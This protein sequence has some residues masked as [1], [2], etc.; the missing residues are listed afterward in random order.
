MGDRLVTVDGRQVV[1]SAE[2]SK[3]A[4][5]LIVEDEALVASSIEEVLAELGFHVAGIAASGP[6][7]LSL[8][9]QSQ[10]ALALASRF[11]PPTESDSPS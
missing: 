2:T 8:A 9:A 5:I 10:P 4:T 7:A 11:G 1:A 3:P 6:E